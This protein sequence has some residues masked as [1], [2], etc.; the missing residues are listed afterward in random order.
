MPYSREAGDL[1]ADLRLVRFL[2]EHNMEFWASPLPLPGR[3]T[4]VGQAHRLGALTVTSR[5]LCGC[6]GFLCAHA[7][8]IAVWE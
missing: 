8:E 4:A 5:A 3:F 7:R 2:A 1:A 6:I